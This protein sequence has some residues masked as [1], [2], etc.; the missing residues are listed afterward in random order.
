MSY[1]KSRLFCLCLTAAIL[2]SGMHGGCTSALQ[3]G[4]SSDGKAYVSTARPAIEVSVAN[5]PLV[6]HGRGKGTLLEPGI[7]GGLSPDTWISVYSRGAQG[8]C[9]VIAH[10]ELD[11][12]IW[13]TVWPRPG[14]MDIR[15]EVIDGISFAA[16]TFVRESRSDPFAGTDGEKEE[17]VAGTQCWLVRS[18]AAVLGHRDEKIILEYRIPL[19]EGLP[20]GG[21]S[22]AYLAQFRQEA[23]SAFSIRKPDRDSKIQDGY[24]EGIRW[25]FVDDAFLGPVMPA[26]L[27]D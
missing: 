8:P 12:W 4:T 23:L 18:M 7:L 20:A 19:P 21:L 26:G 17:Q 10:A 22:E 6:T 14:A 25:R 15:Q 5:L 13:T 11:G 2:L 3:R 16:S 27:Q 24:A 1:G 9:A